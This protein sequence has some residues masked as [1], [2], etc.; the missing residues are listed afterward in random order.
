MKPKKFQIIFLLSVLVI[1]LSSLNAEDRRSIPLDIYLII[2]DSLSFQNLKDDA[3]N[4]LNSQVVE[5]I[6]QDGDKITIWAAGDRA[7]VVYSDTVSETAGK[8]AIKDKIKTLNTIGESADFSGA[9]IN[10]GS[11]V[12]RTS[13]D[14]LAYTMLIIGS[15]KGLATLTGDAQELL[16]WFR[17][18]KYEGWQVL[19]A[20]PDIGKK[21]KQAGAAYMS[22]LR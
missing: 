6:L 15:A 9:L 17:S 20:A 22:S 12:S 5:R 8:N 4:W 7:E 13:G 21:V 10:A 2:D 18:E 14:R 3:I 11:M 16:R 19:V 1:I